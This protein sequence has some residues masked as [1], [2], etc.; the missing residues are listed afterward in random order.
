M[1]V[2]LSAG[3]A[4]ARHCGL[5]LGGLC[6]GAALGASAWHLWPEARANARAM[7]PMAQVRIWQAPGAAAPKPADWLQTRAALAHALAASPRNADLQEAMAYLYLSAALGPGQGLLVQRAY[8]QQAVWHLEQATQARPMVPSAW[9]AEVLVLDRLEQ[10][11]QDAPAGAETPVRRE[12]MWAAFDRALAYGAREPAVQRHLL[13]VALNRWPQLSAPRAT[14][15]RRLYTRATPGQQRALSA[16]A[17]GQPQALA[18]L[19]T[20]DT[21]GR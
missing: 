4:F 13:L 5:L 19:Q 3:L 10:L 7:Q 21:D 8:L 12:A 18:W 17:A 2:G 11:A 1:P 9:A 16:L 20:G 14:A 15:L 6:C